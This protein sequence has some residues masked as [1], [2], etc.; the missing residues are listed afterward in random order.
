[1]NKCQLVALPPAP[2]TF[3][4]FQPQHSDDSISEASN[5]CGAGGVESERG[6]EQTGASRGVVGV[7]EN[8]GSGEVID[9][10]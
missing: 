5:E 2:P 1:M 3:A 4:H 6:P 7:A 10:D 9:S 8:R